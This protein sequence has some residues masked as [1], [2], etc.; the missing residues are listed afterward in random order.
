MLVQE[1]QPERDM[2]R[3]PLFQVMMV[4]QNAPQQALELPGLKLSAFATPNRTAKFD[5]MLTM[6]EG[7]DGL[8]GTLEYDTDLFEATTIKRLLGHFQ[9]LLEKHCGS[10]G[11]ASHGIF[12][13]DGG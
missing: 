10:P 5:L 2:S 11:A 12:S 3:S 6:V 7:A 1:L 8:D 9:R 4:L 13:P